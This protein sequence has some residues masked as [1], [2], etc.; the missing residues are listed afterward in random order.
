M[1]A[2]GTVEAFRLQA[3]FC[4]QMGSPLYAELLTRAADDVERG[5]PVA[6]LLDGWTGNPVPDALVLRLMGAAHEMVL[7]GA[8]PALAR[9]YPSAGGE[10]QWPATWDAFIDLVATQRERLRPA[11]DRHVQTNEVRR[12]FALLGGFL[13]VART[14]GLPLRTLEI[15]SSAG[16]NSN[17]DCYRYERTDADV[18]RHVWG[19][20]KSTVAIRSAWDGADDVFATAATVAQRA[21]CDVA[22]I[23]V[24]DDTQVRRLESFVWADQVE[25]FTQ[26]RSA[27]AL[28]R[29]QPPPLV[30][31][32]AG[33]WL[34]EQLAAPADGVATVVFH[35]IMWWYM[36]EEERDR[37][38]H[39][40]AAAGA[41]ATTRAPLAWLRLELMTSPDAD[42]L[43]THWPGG[44]EVRLGRA[45]AHGRFVRWEG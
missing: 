37:V 21:G 27:I 13:T 15:G 40:I 33:E 12:S 22:P 4:R 16:L 42:L 31:R 18:P 36:P 44:E 5:G 9:F 30:R 29:A 26:L 8:A 20:S 17:W 24:T 3:D 1:L 10:P 19:D 41:R 25:R 6:A 32:P 43:V 35:S 45:D 7:A 23:D 2:P 34:A 14:H 39:V 38:S 11:L 28:A